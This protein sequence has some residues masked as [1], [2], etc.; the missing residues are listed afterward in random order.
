MSKKTSNQETA[1]INTHT[2]IFT[3]EHVPKYLA[4][5]MLPNPVYKW[6]PTIPMVRTI[7]CYLKLEID[8]TEGDIHLRKLWRCFKNRNK[9]EKDIDDEENKSYYSYTAR[10]K[11]HE[12]YLAKKNGNKDL[13]KR[14]LNFFI[15]AFIW[16]IFLLYVSHLILPFTEGTLIGC[17][18]NQYVQLLDFMPKFSTWN[19]ILL[20]LVMTL[21]FKTIREAL[22]RYLIKRIIKAIGKERLDFLLRYI[23]IARFSMSSGQVYIFN[24][25]KQQYPNGSKFVVLPMDMEYMDADAVL[26]SYPDQ[27][28]ELIQIKNN[29][30]NKDILLP[31]IFVD[32][33]RIREHGKS[34]LNLNTSNPNHIILEDCQVKDY[35]D[36]GCIG[37]K[38]Y[39]A[40]GYYPFDQDLLPLWLYCQQENIPIT[41]H[42]S[43][44]PVF[45]R[46]N[47]EDLGENYD[48]HPIFDEVYKKDKVTKKET[49][50]SLRFDQLKNKDFQ[51]NFTHP[52][53]YLCLLHE[54]L[55]IKFLAKE[56]VKDEIRQLFGFNNGKITRN[57][58]KLK[59]NLAH[60]GSAPM[61]QQ[62]LDQ[63]RYSMANEIFKWPNRGL[64]L[65][66]IHESYGNLY[67]FWHY[68]DWFS[69]I[70]SMM[71]QFEN[72]YTDVSY[73]SHDLK[74]LNLLSEI[75]DKPK[76]AERV[77][78]GTDFY[79]VSNHK[80]EKQ[81]WIDM[82]NTLGAEKWE[83]ISNSNPKDF[84]E[85]TFLRTKNAFR[86]YNPKAIIDNPIKNIT[87][88]IIVNDF[89]Q[90]SKWNTI[91]E[92]ILNHFDVYSSIDL[93]DIG[94][95]SN[96]HNLEIDDLLAYIGYLS[97]PTYKYLNIQFFTLAEIKMGNKKEIYSKLK[98]YWKNNTMSQMDWGKWSKNEYLKWSLNINN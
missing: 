92:L 6:F 60:Y 86:I 28:A 7:K 31:F 94:Y 82:Q 2:H 69:I 91:R 72:L 62:F 3:K 30:D 38:I 47:L 37:I 44:G 18:C 12:E 90:G 23:N 42:C 36:N 77:L 1:F 10:A 59:I 25:L 67:Q 45:Y 33:R 55:L 22:K 21:L 70:T 81:Y 49:I 85:S 80:T 79:V 73:T 75:L 56:E 84:L 89:G 43:I 83:K 39:P 57:L 63:D 8:D 76:V 98:T 66:T 40:L 24:Q 61:W 20:V 11:R 54:P 65:Q 15:S 32:P 51:K 46:G 27:M 48:L 93:N 14:I 71:L 96:R 95:M 16:L 64:N 19:T 52:L 9:S 13:K 41:T 26:N 4:K 74:Y 87:K 34:F 53:N 78:Y 29:P 68:V 5:Q 58:S 97:S 17:L 88:A 50:D 35:I